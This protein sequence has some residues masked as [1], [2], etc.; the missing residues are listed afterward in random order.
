MAS[1][2]PFYQRGGPHP[3]REEQAITGGHRSRAPPQSTDLDIFPYST[4]SGAATRRAI[5]L[6]RTETELCGASKPAI[7]YGARHADRV[8][9]RQKMT[10]GAGARMRRV[11]APTSGATERV[12][13]RA[14]A[15]AGSAR[16]P[17]LLDQRRGG[18]TAKA[19]KKEASA[20]APL[21]LPDLI[22]RL[23]DHDDARQALMILYGSL[24][25]GRIA[26]TGG[27]ASIRLENGDTI[28]LA[29]EE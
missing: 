12:I 19:G 13:Y 29:V 25:S 26:Q 21:T 1:P 6:R 9:A 20:P 11:R 2:P 16:P 18:D 22:G 3:Q 8:R 4:T 27:V 5:A 14:P 28:C 10:G 17:A 15:T 24:R 7:R 23:G